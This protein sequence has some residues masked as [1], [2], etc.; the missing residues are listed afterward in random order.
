MFVLVSLYLLHH[1]LELSRFRRAGL[2]LKN[3]RQAPRNLC[4]L[5]IISN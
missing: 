2:S 3:S 4:Q 5:I 1:C